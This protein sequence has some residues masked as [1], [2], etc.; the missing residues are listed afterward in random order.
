MKIYVVVEG[1]IGMGEGIRD[2]R[3]Y[4]SLADAERSLKSAA[5]D[6]DFDL[7]R[8]G[9]AERLSAENGEGAYLHIRD[10]EVS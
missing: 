5:K 2:D 4:F 9:E 10:V 3:G 6:L 7:H 8:D 1:Y